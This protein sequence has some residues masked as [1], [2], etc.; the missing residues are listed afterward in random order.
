MLEAGEIPSSG[1]RSVERKSMVST[2]G[3]RSENTMASTAG[4]RSGNAPPSGEGYKKV[5]Y[6]RVKHGG[7]QSQSSHHRN[8]YG[9]Q[10][11]GTYGVGQV[12]SVWACPMSSLQKR[13]LPYWTGQVP[14]GLMSL[15][16]Q[17]RPY[18]TGLYRIQVSQVPKIRSQYQPV[19]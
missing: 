19:C 7:S 15:L 13:P 18:F 5:S 3:L 12:S 2:A 16:R 10:R 17:I 11:Q 14:K 4:L 9:R 1:L 6:H 8:S